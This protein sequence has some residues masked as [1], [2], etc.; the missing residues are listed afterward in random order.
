VKRQTADGG[1]RPLRTR[2][3]GVGLVLETAAVDGDERELG[4]DEEGVR[5]DEEENQQQAEGDVDGRPQ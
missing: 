1:E 5:A 3:S 4:R 2:P